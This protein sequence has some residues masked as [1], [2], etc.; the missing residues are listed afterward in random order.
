M[1]T[2][3]PGVVALCSILGV[4]PLSFSAQ[5]QNHTLA[6]TTT[7][8]ATFLVSVVVDNDCLISGSN[9]LN[10]GHVA[11]RLGAAA[12]AWS[13]QTDQVTRFSVSCTRNTRYTLYL[14]KGSVADSS[15]GTRLMAG[16][17]PGNTDQLRY[18]L[19][20]DPAY[21]TIWGDGSSGSTGSV[22]GV[23]SGGPQLYTVYGR[24]LPQDMPNADLYSS[25]IT[26]SL[27][28]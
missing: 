28:F 12:G 10:F 21:S 22:S 3:P 18:Q 24:I 6:G 8:T 15:V 11:T 9:A 23:G 16:N 20:L 13:G 26:A 4:A 7:R 17:L 19:Y 2:I 1:R 25:M 14:D 27:T 5:A